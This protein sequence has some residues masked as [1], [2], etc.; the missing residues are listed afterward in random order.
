MSNL[1][2]CMIVSQDRHLVIPRTQWQV[3]HLNS[4]NTQVALDYVV[5]RPYTIYLGEFSRHQGRFLSTGYVNLGSPA[6]FPYP[7]VATPHHRQKVS[8]VQITTE[9][10]TGAWIL[11]FRLKPSLALN[12]DSYL[13]ASS[14]KMSSR[15]LG[16]RSLGAT[17]E[18]PPGIAEQSLKSINLKRSSELLC[19]PTNP[20]LQE[21]FKQASSRLNVPNVPSRTIRWTWWTMDRV[22]WRMRSKAQSKL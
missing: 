8:T 13:S 12:S 9:T 16:F 14:S 15:T 22:C 1:W 7:S 17:I 20:S 11:S 19:T 10:N 4:S 5:S 2:F 18:S 3:P 21:N 6:L